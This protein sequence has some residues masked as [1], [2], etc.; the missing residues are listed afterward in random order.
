VSHSLRV[1][2]RKRGS[3][4]SAYVHGGFATCTSS[5]PWFGHFQFRAHAH[6]RRADPGQV[7][8]RQRSQEMSD[9]PVSRL[10]PSSPS[11][12]LTGAVSD[13]RSLSPTGNTTAGCAAASS[14]LSL[15]HPPRYSLSKSNCSP[16]QIPP[17]LPTPRRRTRRRLYPPERDETSAPSCSWRIGRRVEGRKWTKDSW[18]G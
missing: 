10:Y 1:K 6:S 18:G 16:P 8:G 12:S 11:L 13:P 17:R 14:V 15:P 7:G 5:V 2:A 9:M 3:E 4:V